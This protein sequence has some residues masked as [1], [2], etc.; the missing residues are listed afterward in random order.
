M[1]KRLDQVYQF[2]ISLANIQPLIWRRIQVPES[3]SFWDLHVAI[4]D[5]MGWDDSHLHMFIMEIGPQTGEQVRIGIPDD[6]PMEES[7][8]PM[9][10]GWTQGIGHY[11]SME[12]RTAK[13]IYDFGDDWM[14]M[15]ELEA[16]IPGE[17]GRKYPVCIGAEKA[18][19]P[20][21]CGGI[22]GYLDFLEAI[23]NPHHEQHDEMLEWI[24]GKFDP[25]RFDAD[26][27]KFSDPARRFKRAFGRE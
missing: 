8:K 7:E 13:Y 21:D 12:N 10:P 20:E 22:P 1:K 5:A 26:K 4:Q 11:F 18:C 9:L 25:D 17:T 3:Y 16:I 15:V 24:G 6:E 19:P 14:H 2:K 23:K 27:I